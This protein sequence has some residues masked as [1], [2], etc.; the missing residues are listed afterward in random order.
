[1]GQTRDFLRTKINFSTFWLTESKCTEKIILKS[2]GFFQ[3]E[4]NLIQ[5]RA[6]SVIPESVRRMWEKIAWR[7]ESFDF[8]WLHDTSAELSDFGPKLGHIST[9]CNT[10]GI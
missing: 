10:D 9:K 5:F 2:P 8:W 3:F 4:T 6:K 7:S 1:M